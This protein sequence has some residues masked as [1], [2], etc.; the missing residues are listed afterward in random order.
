MR[1]S[2]S[3]H[4]ELDLHGKTV[5]EAISLVEES[6]KE[7]YNSHERRVWIIHGKGTG[8]LREEVRR[9]LKNHGYLLEE[10]RYRDRIRRPEGPLYSELVGFATSLNI[11]PGI[12]ALLDDVCDKENRPHVP[13]VK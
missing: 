5:N 10:E 7:S 12:R 1:N 13:T 8:V 6:L 9:H 11:T 4:W 2:G 3:R